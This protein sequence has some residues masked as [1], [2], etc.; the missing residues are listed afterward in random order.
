MSSQKG[1]D[2]VASY[3]LRI[4]PTDH[5]GRTVSLMMIAQV[6]GMIVAQGR[7]EKGKEDWKIG[8]G[9]VDG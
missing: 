1:P 5:L 6:V 9:K 2:S 4:V 7:W 8:S 3:D